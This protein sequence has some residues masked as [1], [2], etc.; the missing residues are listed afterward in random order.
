MSSVRDD[1]VDSQNVSNFNNKSTPFFAWMILGVSIF[2]VSSAGSVFELIDDVSPI[3]KAAWRLQATSIVLLPPFLWQLKNTE[4]NLRKKWS[5]HFNLLFCSGLFLAVHFGTWLISLDHTTLTH[6]LLFVTAHPLVI[7]VGLW[8]LRKPATK[9]QSSGA[10]VG[11]AGAT[12]VILGGANESGVSIF[13]DLMAFIGAITV[14][15]YLVIGRMVRGWM[16][17]FLYALPVTLVAALILSLWGYISEGSE[18]TFSPE[19]GLFGWINVVWFTYVAYLAIGP[20]L[21]G[22]TGINGVLRWIPTL[23]ISMVLI[24]EPVIGSFIG[25]LIG[26]DSIPSIWTLIGGSVMIL[27]LFLVTLDSESLAGSN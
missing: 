14:V 25:W 23:T 27:G 26:V 8:I 20:G 16:P 22:H 11:F 13:G 17:L 2:A 12:I 15:G 4:K 10:I 19:G 24:M 18:L 21:A 3:T 5:E 6:S 1:L 9:M 7:I